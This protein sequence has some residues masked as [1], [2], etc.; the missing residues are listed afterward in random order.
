MHEHESTPDPAR[1][2]DARSE[3]VFDSCV[4]STTNVNPVDGQRLG[5][6]SYRDSWLGID[7]ASTPIPFDESVGQTHAY[8]GDPTPQ[9]Y[10]A[11]DLDT[12]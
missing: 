2:H 10:E 4:V 3:P 8:S 7:N 1:S 9:A 12:D 11:F 6:P 5:L